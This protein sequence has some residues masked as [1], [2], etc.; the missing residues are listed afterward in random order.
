VWGVKAMIFTLSLVRIAITS[1]DVWLEQLSIKGPLRVPQTLLSPV[2]RWNKGQRSY[3]HAQ[4][5]DSRPGT[6][7]IAASIGD[8]HSSERPRALA[9][10]EDPQSPAMSWCRTSRTLQQPWYV[11]LSMC[12]S[13]LARHD[14]APCSPLSS[15]GTTFFSFRSSY[16]GIPISS[17]SNITS[18]FIPWIYS[19]T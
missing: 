1:S 15:S 5:K 7:W 18:A 16:S 9:S 8:R 12:V 2:A 10:C 3:S 19:L 11:C 17:R 13:H 6:L 14:D 4:G